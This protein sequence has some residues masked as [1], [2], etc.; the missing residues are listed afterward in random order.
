MGCP[1]EED[2][3]VDL[4]VELRGRSGCSSECTFVASF[5]RKGIGWLNEFLLHFFRL[6]HSGGRLDALEGRPGDSGGETFCC[7][8]GSG[9]GRWYR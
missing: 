2:I 8:A 6:R 5:R 4:K 7:S 9:G 3:D 1:R